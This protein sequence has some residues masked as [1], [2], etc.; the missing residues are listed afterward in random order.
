MLYCEKCG[1][2]VE[3]YPMFGRKQHCL[4]CNSKLRKESKIKIDISK[5]EKQMRIRDALA[6]KPDIQP[7]IQC[8][9]CHKW[10]EYNYCS[11]YSHRCSGR[12]DEIGRVAHR[13]F[14]SISSLRNRDTRF[15][16]MYNLANDLNS[17][18]MMYDPTTNKLSRKDIEMNNH[19]KDRIK[20][21]VRSIDHAKERI[22]Y[23]ERLRRNDDYVI[24]IEHKPND[25]APET[26]KNGYEI[27]N[28]IVHNYQ[29]NLEKY[30]KELDKLLT[31][32]T[33]GIEQYVPPKDKRWRWWKEE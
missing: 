25:R 20:N 9:K 13:R 17:V 22:L 28:Q 30:N 21:L 33:T 19:K 12:V 2:W 26:I 29:Q 16:E 1:E 23:F 7:S 31:P 11:G 3:Y 32:E 6:E 27:I 18:S 5:L 14:Y 24:V 10:I 8:D 4:I 15:F